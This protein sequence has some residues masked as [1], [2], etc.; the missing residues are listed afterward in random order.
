MGNSTK[1]HKWIVVMTF[2]LT[3]LSQ[4][5]QAQ[6]GS[7]GS[8]FVSSGGE[9]AIFGQHNFITGSG[10]INAGIVGSERQPVIGV[11]SFVDPNGSWINASSTAFMD[12]YVRTYNAGA[13][14]FPIGDN[15]VYRPAAVSASSNTAPTTA[16]YFGVDPTTAITSNLA[17]GS[18]GVLPTGGPFPTT[19]KAANVGTVDNVEYWDIDGTTPAKITLTWDANTPIATMVG[20]SLSRLSIVGWNGTQWV[21]IPSSFDVSS[22]IQ[23][24]SAS[25]FTGPAS[26]VASGSITTTSAI[27]PDTYT[28]YTLAASCALI[29]SSTPDTTVCSAQ[30]ATLTITADSVAV[31]TWTN[32]LGQSGTGTTINFAGITNVSGSPQTITY[33]IS[34]TSGSCVDSKVI[35]LTVNLAP[36]L[37]VNLQQAVICQLGKTNLIANAFPA[38][39]TI[40]WT[41]TPATPIPA[42]GTGTGSLTI[43][44]VLPVGSYSYSFT[45]TEGACT[46]PAVV[47]PVMVNN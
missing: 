19:S 11:Y 22:L 42:S 33:V 30:P 14:T 36:A 20:T 37:Q 26:V 45:A 39:A 8:T 16:A 32:S 1:K 10:T 7:F 18:Y 12:A 35:T 2:V 5:I 31:V 9:M 41:R 44:Q 15:N 4:R 17:G 34:A 27:V 3:A 24:T 29:T 21:V 6:S 40:N 38:T 25:A 13:F 47:V 23:T 28:V 46:S 43:N